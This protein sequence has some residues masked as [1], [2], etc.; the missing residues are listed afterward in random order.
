MTTLIAEDEKKRNREALQRIKDK[1]E[2]DFEKLITYICSGSLALTFTFIEKIVPFKYSISLW[3]LITG[4]VLL[5]WTLL[6]NL[7]SHYYSKHLIDKTI[8]DIDNDIPDLHLIIAKRNKS[9]NRVNISTIA[10]LI[11]GILLIFCFVSVNAINMSNTK[12]ENVNPAKRD[13]AQN[14]RSIPR[15]APTSTNE[16]KQPNKSDKK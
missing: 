4:W 2:D 14:G 15:I 11:L 13:K 16:P 3:L 6:I 8:D 9:I 7:A 1:C 12:K 10:T 5:V